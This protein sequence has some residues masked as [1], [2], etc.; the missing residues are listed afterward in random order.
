MFST[1]DSGWYGFDHAQKNHEKPKLAL[2]THATN[3]MQ[4]LVLHSTMGT[5]WLFNVALENG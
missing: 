1:N 3:D 4:T 5:L 2:L